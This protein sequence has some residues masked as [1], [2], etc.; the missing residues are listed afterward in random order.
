MSKSCYILFS[1]IKVPQRL[2][3]DLKLG[4]KTVERE[5]FSKVLGIYIDEKLSSP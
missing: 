1:S 5:T 4:T 3:V 2:E